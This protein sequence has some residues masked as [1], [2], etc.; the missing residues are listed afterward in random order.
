MWSKLMEVSTAICLAGFPLLAA[1]WAYNEDWLKAIFM[2]QVA[3]FI[4]VMGRQ[5]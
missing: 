1:L 3:T 4:A 5:K 2:L